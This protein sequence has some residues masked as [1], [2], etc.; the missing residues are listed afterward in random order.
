MA[1]INFNKLGCKINNDI[2]TLAF[3]GIE[4]EI[5]QYLSIQEKLQIMQ[6][7]IIQ[8]MTEYN[9]AN[10]VQVEVFTYLEIIQKYTNIK[11]TEKQL[12]DPAKLYDLIK[13]SNLLTEICNKIPTSEIEEIK[14]GVNKSITSFYAYRNSIL[15]ILETLKTDYSNLN[16][17]LS[18]ILSQIQDPS[19]LNILREIAPVLQSLG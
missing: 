16:L 18:N 15:G 6:N 12:Q 8:S 9:Y 4:I 19:A 7:V 13:S 1:H 10:L 5:I 17:D 14:S 11:F 2:K 3:N